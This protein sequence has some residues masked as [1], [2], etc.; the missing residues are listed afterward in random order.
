MSM[1]G[2]RKKSKPKSRE[3]SKDCTGSW[4]SKS[5]LVET[6]KKNPKNKKISKSCLEQRK[7]GGGIRKLIFPKR[8]LTTEELLGNLSQFQYADKRKKSKFCNSES[9]L[10]SYAD[11]VTS[12]GIKK[13]KIGKNV[14]NS[15][16]REKRNI[17][18]K[19]NFIDNVSALKLKDKKKQKIYPIINEKDL[20]IPEN[21]KDKLNRMDMD[22]DNRTTESILDHGV[23]K[24]F[25][26]LMKAVNQH[27]KNRKLTRA[28]SGK[29]ADRGDSVDAKT[30]KHPQAVVSKQ[31]RKSLKLL[32]NND[33]KEIKLN[34]SFEELSRN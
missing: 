30:F 6:L 33:E 27:K 2:K 23:R 31:R 16:K 18:I 19:T 11:S 4:K 21:L 13:L 24:N 20:K 28:M 22:N 10:D 15:W 32:P 5:E 7:L 9:S 1:L 29:E 17:K 8:V 26:N 12:V 34:N 14:G 3:R 25:T